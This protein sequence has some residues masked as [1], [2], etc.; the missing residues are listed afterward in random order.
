M[1]LYRPEY[2]EG[3]RDERGE[4]KK[5]ADGTPMEGLAEVIVAKQRNGP[6]DT[7]RLFFHKQ[8]TRFE[9]FA[10]REPAA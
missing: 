5:L 2:Y 9:P 8:F 3:T 6:T 10:Q 1:F 7:V 4:P